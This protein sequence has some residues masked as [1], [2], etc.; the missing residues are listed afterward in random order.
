MINV[1]TGRNP[2]DT[3]M[4][5][6]DNKLQQQRRGIVVRE[7]GNPPK[8]PAYVQVKRAQSKRK[9]KQVRLGI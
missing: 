3:A 7:N 5:I 8:P 4:Q 2:V 1:N 6:I 9:P